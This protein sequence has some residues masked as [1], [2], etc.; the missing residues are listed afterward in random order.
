MSCGSMIYS[1]P[2][3]VIF[4]LVDSHAIGNQIKSVPLDF[5]PFAAVCLQILNLVYD[6][7]VKIRAIYTQSLYAS[8]IIS[9]VPY[10]GNSRVLIS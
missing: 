3:Q 4:H 9:C 6:R 1:N 10:Y 2:I 5:T 8:G 7:A